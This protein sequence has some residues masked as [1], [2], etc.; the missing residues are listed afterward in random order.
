MKNSI[1]CMLSLAV[2]TSTF[3]G[4]ARASF[5]VPIRAGGSIHFAW[6]GDLN[7]DGQQDYLIDRNTT[8][9]Q[10]IEAYN[11]AGTFLWE[12]NFGPNSANQDNISPGSATIDVGHNDGVTVYDVNGDGRSEVIIKFANGVRFGNG[13]TFSNSNNNLQWIGVLNGATGALLASAP[14]PTDFLSIGSVS[15]WLGVGNCGIVFFAKNRNSNGSFTQL[16]TVYTWNGSSSLTLKWKQTGGG[17]VSHQMRIVDVNGDGTDDIAHIG[18]AYNGVNGATLYTL[19]GVVH[20]DRYHIA[21]MDPAQS[22]LQ[23]YGIQQD[24]PN[25]L[26]EYYYNAANGTFF[27]KHSGAVTDVGRGD[28]GDLDGTKPGWEVFSFDGV[29]NA[30]TNTLLAQPAN[31]PWPSLRLWWDA[32]D[33][34]DSYNDGKIE[35]FVPNMGG[36]GRWVTVMTRIT[37][38]ASDAVTEDRG[39]PLFYG[40]I[41]GDWREE[42]IVGNSANNKLY[43]LTPPGTSNTRPTLRNDRY[44][45]NCLSIKGYMQSHHVSFYIGADTPPSGGD[46]YQ[47]ESA[48]PAGGV[49]FDTN[50]NGYNGTG[51]ANFPATGGTLTFNNIDGNGGGTKSLA[52]R[53]ANGSATTR[54]GTIRINGGTATSIS[55]PSTGGWTNWTALNVNITL[56]N[57]ST[58]S[59]QFASTGTDLGNID[60]ITVP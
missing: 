31:S 43:V 36:S 5:T 45:R 14:V 55:F 16:Q 30:R 23:G 58:N 41:M 25:G 34:A 51:F 44:Y 53:Y 22:G 15:G 11:H 3:I 40:D 37:D 57:N 19:S 54:T 20:G 32:N 7:G 49:T 60:E 42:V 17:A 48:T 47:A 9:P 12:V 39:A 56:N 10:T 52:I 18:F 28:A 21:K 35:K 8:N 26:H 1:K 2:V 38:Y 13:V 6:V 59:I 24:N 50:N 4:S 33:L 29:H 46:T 27:W